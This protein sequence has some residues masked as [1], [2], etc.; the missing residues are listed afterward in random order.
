VE[1]RHHHVEAL[2]HAQLNLYRQLKPR[3]RIRLNRTII[4]R[5]LS[6]RQPERELTLIQPINKLPKSIFKRV[7]NIA[8]H[9]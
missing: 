2:D 6:L 9:N 4:Q 5:Q 1:P 3:H 8:F 7:V